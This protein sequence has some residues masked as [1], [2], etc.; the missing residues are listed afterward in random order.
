MMLWID[1]A[2]TIMDMDYADDIAL[3][4]NTPTQ[5]LLHSLEQATAGIVS[6]SMQT[7]WNTCAFNQRGDIYMLRS[8]PLKLMDRFTNLRSSVSSTEKDY[9]KAWRAIN[10]LS[11]IWNLE[12]TN[13]IKRSFHV[14][15]TAWMHYMDAN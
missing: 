12:M 8:G 6:M 15:T 4:A 5:S 2:Q 1:P 14:D 7:R 9:Q 11:V 13:K 3:R 10:R